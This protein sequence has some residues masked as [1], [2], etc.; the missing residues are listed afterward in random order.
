MDARTMIKTLEY[1]ICDQ[2]ELNLSYLPFIKGGGLFIPTEV[3]FYLDDP[4]NV[5]LNLFG[6]HYKIEGKVVWITPKNSIYHIH[7]GVGIELIGLSAKSICEK[8]RTKLDGSALLGGYAYGLV[9]G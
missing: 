1:D 4:V 5:E 2:S 7:V 3:T 9:S 8:I 6:E